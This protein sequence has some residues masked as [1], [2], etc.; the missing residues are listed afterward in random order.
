MRLIDADAQQKREKI[1]GK[2]EQMRSL[3]QANMR[4][5]EDTLWQD[6]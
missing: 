2:L 5:R 6:E 1:E 3:A 4:D